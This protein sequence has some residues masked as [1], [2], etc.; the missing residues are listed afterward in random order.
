MH[1]SWSRCF[2][3]IRLL[4]LKEGCKK[5]L[6]NYTWSGGADKKSTSQGAV[7]CVFGLNFA[8]MAWCLHL[9]AMQQG[10]DALLKTVKSDSS[11]CSCVSWWPRAAGSRCQELRVLPSCP[12]SHCPEDIVQLRV[13]LAQP[14]GPCGLVSHLHFGDLHLCAPVRAR[15]HARHLSKPAPQ[16]RHRSFICYSPNQG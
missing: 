15:S 9:Q 6:M 7:F 12:L 1:G 13:V 4:S 10:R 8:R 5:G 16:Y 3:I 2:C 11:V 14:D